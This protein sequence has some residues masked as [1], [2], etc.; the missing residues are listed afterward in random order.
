MDQINQWL[1]QYLDDHEI[2]GHF[3][4]KTVA[5]GKTAK[6]EYEILEFNSYGK[7]LL[8]NGGIQSTQND[9]HCY[10]E[11]LLFPSFAFNPKI[12]SVLCIGGANGGPLPRLTLFP[13]LARILLI[14]IDQELHT[15]SQKYLSHMHHNSLNDPR[16]KIQFGNPFNLVTELANNSSE[17][18]DL[19]IA[20]LP[21]ATPDSYAP[22]LFSMEFYK[23]V[24]CLLSKN[25][26][27]VT[28]A[29]QAHFLKCQFHLR[30]IKTLKKI[31]KFV[32]S[33]TNYVPSYGVP[34][35]FAIASN[36]VDF[37]SIDSDILKNQ[38]ATL[39]IKHLQTY[40]FESHLHM[41]NLPRTLRENLDNDLPVITLLDMEYVS[42]TK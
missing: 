15:I 24:N 6:Q 1:L 41:F 19:I 10:H 32:T 16:I 26:I 29:G 25:G 20:D 8:L 35:G 2:H 14:D 39:P 21:D 38:I 5:K 40:D 42:V 11:A 23:T 28:Q 12:Q 33:Y 13:D 31:F 27:F 37:S 34:W 4:G 7:T 22:N 3:C 18:F 30:V 9:E 17:R 36:S